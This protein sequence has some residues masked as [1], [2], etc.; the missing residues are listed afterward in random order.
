MSKA[1]VDLMT[2]EVVSWIRP[3]MPDDQRDPFNTAIK[4]QEELSE[5]L[6]AMH[7]GDGSIGEEL[8]DCMVLILDIAHLTSS[9]IVTEFWDKM[10]KN[11]DRAWHKKNGSL[12]HMKEIHVDHSNR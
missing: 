3:L 5:L 1:D 6:H 12:H 2:T 7:T 11:R 10:E 8:A 9:D 4:L